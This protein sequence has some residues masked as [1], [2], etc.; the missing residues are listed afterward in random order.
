MKFNLFRAA[1]GTEGGAPSGTP[2]IAAPPVVHNSAPMGPT[3]I[4]ARDVSVFYGDKQALF[5][6]S[7]D[8]PGKAVTA[9][10]KALVLTLTRAV[11]GRMVWWTSMVVP[12]LT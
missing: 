9:S 8:I 6:V 10:S 11:S 4:A 7:L 3:K 1:D 5:D 2:V 12:R